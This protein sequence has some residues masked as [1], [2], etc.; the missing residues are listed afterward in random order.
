MLAS[1]SLELDSKVFVTKSFNLSKRF[2]STKRIYFCWEN[3][4]NEKIKKQKSEEI[5]T[6]I[7]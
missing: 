2:F 1:R 7:G 3:P 6:F 5:N 4:E